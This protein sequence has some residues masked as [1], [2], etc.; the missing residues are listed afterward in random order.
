MPLVRMPQGGL[1]ARALL[2]AT[3]GCGSRSSLSR[4]Q[5]TGDPASEVEPCMTTLDCVAADRCQPWVCVG[6]YCQPDDPVVCADSDPCTEDL[7]DPASGECLFLP[8]SYDLDG[9]GYPGPRPGYLPGAPGS[10]GHDCNDR[11][12]QARPGGIEVCDGLDND[13]NGVVDDSAWFA[14]FPAEPVRITGSEF[15]YATSSSLVY[16]GRNYGVTFSGTQT[17]KTRGYFQLLTAA[18]EAAGD[19]LA[20]TNVG[21]DSTAGPLVWNGCWFATTWEDRRENDYE[22]H[23]NRLDSAGQKLGPDV[24]VSFLPDFSI[25]SDLLWNGREYL[26]VWTQLEQDGHHAIWGQRL[27][28]DGQLVGYNVQLTPGSYGEKPVLV[29]GATKLALVYKSGELTDQR[30]AL[31]T[32]NPD[33]S[34]LGEVITLSSLDSVAPSAAFMADRW[35]VVWSRNH[36]GTIGDAIWGCTVSESG[37]I[38]QAEQR[39]TQSFGFARFQTLLPLGNRFLLIWAADPGDGNYDLYVKTLSFEL[40]ELSAEMRLTY[41]AESAYG[42]PSAAFGPN[43]DVGI[44]FS[45]GALPQVYWTHL[46]CQSEMP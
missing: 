14:P 30:I 44:L 19:R 13:C 9:D 31:R 12:P 42:T 28:L 32:L 39:I 26:V 5:A 17:P 16:D 4:D 37:Q 6:G 11:S 34:E 22:I 33:F 40:S 10:C 23:F 36:G 18:G 35:V 2:V 38:L 27:T 29:Q 20:L 1:V 45:D 46:G 43:G 8:Y 3:M 15:R 21:S 25:R 7:C 24:R 41:T